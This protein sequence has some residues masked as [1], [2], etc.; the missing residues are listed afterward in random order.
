VAALPARA[1]GH[2][3]FGYFGRTVRLNDAVI[4]A[5]ARILHA[6]PGSRLMLNNSPFAEAAGRDRMAAR[7]AAHGIARER[8]EMLCTTPQPA[9]W[10]AYGTIDIALDPFPHNAGTTTIEALWMGVPVVSL[11][12]R[13][14]VGRFGA[15]ILRA[16]D[17]DD[18]VTADVDGY[19]DHA[20]RAAADLDALA[21]LRGGL[22]PRFAASALHDADGLARA[23]EAA[24]AA[25]WENWRDGEAPRLRALYTAGDFD[26]ASAL[27]DD[28]LAHRPD[29]A[30]ALH[31]RAL[32]AFRGGDAAAAI[33]TLRQAPPRADLLTDLGVMLR[34]TGQAEQA[35]AAYGRAIGLDQGCAPAHG[36]LGNLL[37]DAGRIA[38]AD[39][40]FAAA[41]AIAPGQPWLLR[42]HALTLL[43][44]QE[45]AA[46]EAL[47]RRALAASP[48]DA[49]A[50]ETLGCLLGQTGRPIE[51][52]AHHR[53]GL[54][55]LR[56]RHRG[57]G[58][59]AVSLQMQGRYQ[60]AE[61]CYR[62]ALDAMPGYASGHGNL[63]FAL[64]YRHDLPPDSIFAEYRAWDAR[65]ARHLAPADDAHD[66][67]RT[68]GR[69]LRVGY[70]SPDFRRHAVAHFALPLFAAHDRAA[71]E[72]TLYAEVA[73]ED[74]ETARFRATADR[75][76]NTAGMTDQALAA[77]IRADG[78]DVLVDMAGH[79]GGNR[80][81]TFA[82]RPAP[83]QIESL[84]GLGTTSGMVAMDAFLADET[85]AP[86]GAEAL[87]AERVIRL[88]RIPL[89]Y[90][91]PDGMP[92]VS[93]PPVLTSGHVTFGYF[94]RVERL[95]PR[96]IAVWSR[97][98]RQVPS[99][100]LML[101]SLPFVEP[102]FRDLFRARFAEHGIAADRLVLVHT[103]PQPATWAAYGGIDIAL[104]PFPHNAGTTTIEALWSGVPVVTRA[105]RPSVGR[106]GAAIL[107]ALDLREWVADDD[108]AYVARAVAAARDVPGLAALRQSLR[109]R[110]EVS[111]LRDGAG[112]ARAMEEA[113]R[114]LWDAWRVGMT[115]A[116]AAE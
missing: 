83:V 82:R 77:A 28:L 23:I 58:N 102:A 67:D 105:D 98:L 93:P 113:Y 8:L 73:Q 17:L 6:V 55:G 60:D 7:F 96:V 69:R 89:V 48:Y 43:A 116:V 37:L 72:L 110:F 86:A 34:A 5:W 108:D 57:L 100:R 84:L 70:V 56:Q 3:T 18:W 91:P 80:L 12:G 75:W 32:I 78:I 81:L 31:I 11:A 39:A 109:R 36:N 45:P 97:I 104:D 101:N 53:A 114:A 35:E 20:V 21:S 42:G 87:F 13:P 74:A 85:L 27:A 4:A 107:G 95:N 47:L 52:E 16:L 88:P 76:R 25:L 94:G 61:A 62:Q 46:A 14:T 19:V 10:A 63:L 68:P 92:D 24:Y 66:L 1:N 111:P 99:S 103:A 26:A 90:Q 59:L 40:A 50:H 9:T 115:L 38:E 15:A 41:L 106:F 30:D 22:R 44:Q 49:E 33:A 65:H 2:V 51:A 54:P 29:H 79:T 112:L 71:V 64:N